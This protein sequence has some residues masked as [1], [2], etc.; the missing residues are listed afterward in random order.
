MP[1]NHD[2]VVDEENLYAQCGEWSF[3]VELLQDFLGESQE[4]LDNLSNTETDF[5]VRLLHV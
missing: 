1:E 5:K 3:A 4:T 2:R